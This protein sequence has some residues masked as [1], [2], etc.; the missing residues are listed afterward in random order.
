LYKYVLHNDMR[1]APLPIFRYTFIDEVHDPE[2]ALD[3]VVIHQ[4]QNPTRWTSR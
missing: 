1:K 2:V 4:K 3:F